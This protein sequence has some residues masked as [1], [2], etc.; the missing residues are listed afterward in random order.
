[1]MNPRRI[2]QVAS[3]F[4]GTVVLA[5]WVVVSLGTWFDPH[6]AASTEYRP[7]PRSANRGPRSISRRQR[8]ARG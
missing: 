6:R 5:G 2:A 4:C 8:Q 1:M 7:S 3:A